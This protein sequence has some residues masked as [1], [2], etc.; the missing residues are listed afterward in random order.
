MLFPFVPI[1]IGAVMM[2]SGAAIG[3]S[4]AEWNKDINS[5]QCSV[6]ISHTHD[7][8]D[9]ALNM[10]FRAWNGEDNNNFEWLNGGSGGKWSYDKT[11]ERVDGGALDVIQIEAKGRSCIQQININC[12]ED[13]T[14]REKRTV[15]MKVES[16][17]RFWQY[18]GNPSWLDV[19]WGE[20]D[21][22]WFG[23]ER[24]IQAIDVHKCAFDCINTDIE[25]QKD[26]IEVFG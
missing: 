10:N 26:C 21:C 11:K 1:L 17:R 13:V 8:E 20:G 25:C 12:G 5:N 3:S 7:S 2:G 19:E 16:W 18:K 22:M 23:G 15:L 6:I 14:G 9:A 24:A 4:A